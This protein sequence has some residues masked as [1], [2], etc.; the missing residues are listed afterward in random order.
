[1]MYPKWVFNI[2]EDVTRENMRKYDQ[3]KDAFY[4]KGVEMFPNY[5]EMSLVDRYRNKVNEKVEEALGYRL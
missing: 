5:W 4:K 1:M 2:R 3:M